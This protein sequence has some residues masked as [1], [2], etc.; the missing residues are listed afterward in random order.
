MYDKLLDTFKTVAETGSFTKATEILFITHTAIRKQIDQLESRL[1]VKLFER[2]KQGVKLTDAGQVMYAETLRF[3]KES[4]LIVQK[5]RDAYSTN[6]HLLKIGTSVLYPCTYFMDLWDR[7]R[8]N[9]PDYRLKIISFD[10][11]KDRLSHIGKDFDFLIGAFNSEL[12]DAYQFLQVGAYRFCLAVPRNHPLSKRKSLSFKDLSG[13]PL[14]I[15][16]KGNS[17]INDSIR[18]NVEREYPEI[19]VVDTDPH[20]D[21]HTFNHAVERGCILLSLECWDRVHPDIKSIPLKESYTL[22]FGIIY[23]KQAGEPMNE[24]ITAIRLAVSRY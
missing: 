24:F 20:Y 14:M 1:E 7:M 16:T 10:D 23:A 15:M 9:C 12:T 13:Q 17:P 4:D 5:V 18:A 3:I 8:D 21:V 2:S 11:D 6:P 19:S 22:P